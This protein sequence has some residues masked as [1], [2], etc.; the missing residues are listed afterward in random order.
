M[1]L[2][3]DNVYF[4]SIV[5]LVG[6]PSS[7]LAFK[8]CKMRIS[9]DT[10]FHEISH[11]SYS[12]VK[13]SVFLKLKDLTIYKLYPVI[14]DYSKIFNSYVSFNLKKKKIKIHSI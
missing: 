2:Y 5:D 11:W 13:K 12:R 10:K 9:N 7:S 1:Y 4:A 3:P 8:F 6:G 14:D